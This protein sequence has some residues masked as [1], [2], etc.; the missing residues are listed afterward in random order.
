[1]IAAGAAYTGT[2]R[3][4]SPRQGHEV[5]VLDSIRS[6][7]PAVIKRPVRRALDALDRS[8]RMYALTSAIKELRRQAHAKDALDPQLLLDLRGAWGNLAFSADAMFLSEVARRTMTHTGP[9]LECGSGVSTIVAGV[10]AGQRGKRVWALEQ[11]PAWYRYVSGILK[12][13]EIANVTLWY[14]PLERYGDYVWFDLYGRS[15]PREFTDVFCDGPA[16]LKGEWPDPVHS[17]WRVGLI[18][19]FQAR[20]IRFREVVLDDADDPRCA[21]LRRLWEDLGVSTEIVATPSGPFVLGRP[22]E[23]ATQQ[24]H[25]ATGPGP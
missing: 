14:T 19:V 25:V 15:L 13:F 20:G 9:F 22:S 2:A 17:D 12:R 4:Q 16:I 10:I 7:I 11:D 6:H 24:V 8:Q 5:I 3:R 21:R 18:P 23:F 1:M